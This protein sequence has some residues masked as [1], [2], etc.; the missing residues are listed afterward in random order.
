MKTTTRSEKAIPVQ[1]ESVPEKHNKHN[2]G[3]VLKLFRLD[4]KKIS[5]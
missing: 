5:R 2:K 4:L 3:A 1:K